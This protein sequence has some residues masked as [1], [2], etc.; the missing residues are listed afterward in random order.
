MSDRAGRKNTEK[1]NNFILLTL[2][3]FA[4]V[5]KLYFGK[6]AVD[7]ENK[8]KHLTQNSY[9]WFF[10]VDVLYEPWERNS[11]SL[12]R[13]QLI[14][15]GFFKISSVIENILVTIFTKRDFFQKSVKLSVAL[16]FNVHLNLG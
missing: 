1:N 12:Y 5:L 10:L 9:G 4:V 3:K 6:K 7:I 13:D 14:L 11:S 15:F 8:M 2:A 16:K